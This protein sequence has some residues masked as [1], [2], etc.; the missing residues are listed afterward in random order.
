M[1]LVSGL[2]AAA[3]AMLEVVS[4]LQ[5][6]LC[7]L[8]CSIVC[9]SILHGQWVKAKNVPLKSVLPAVACQADDDEPSACDYSAMIR[10]C[11]HAQDME[12]AWE[13]WHEMLAKQDPHTATLSSMVE[14]M[15]S[16]CCVAEAWDLANKVWTNPKL[17]LCGHVAVYSAVLRGFSKA[18][19]HCEVSAVFDE[20]LKRSVPMNTITYNIVLNSIACCGHM[21]RVPELLAAMK[22]AGP[23]SAP[24]SVTFSTVIKGCCQAGDLDMGLKVLD[25]VTT[26]TDFEADRFAYSS[27]LNGCSKH[28][29]MKD[30]LRLID[31]MRRLGITPSTYTLMIAVKFL[32][33]AQR[34][35]EAFAVVQDAI[36]LHSVEPNIQVYT[37]LIQGCFSSRKTK[38]ALELYNKIVQEGLAV[39][40]QK[41]YTVL[42]NGCLA[43]GSPKKAAKVVRCA[44]RLPQTGLLHVAEGRPRGVARDCLEEVLT[45]LRQADH[46]AAQALE[47]ELAACPAFACCRKQRPPV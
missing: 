25:F 11:G 37:C 9:S 6:E 24:D 27:L 41:V 16:N 8:L 26:E 15:V 7:L 13:R 36:E 5:M 45:A 32:G 38:K 1:R 39:V 3:P 34:V 46:S 31:Q 21:H 23:R 10:D 42:A 17:Q 18:K 19:Q 47:A 44:Y 29:R 22:A 43:H 14:A 35:T 12:G 40:D 28:R 20:M 4:S 2:E 33:L 30:G